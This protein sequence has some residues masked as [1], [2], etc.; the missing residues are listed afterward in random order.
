M[1]IIIPKIRMETEVRKL[2]KF[3]HVTQVVSTGKLPDFKGFALSNHRVVFFCKS[4]SSLN[5]I[6]N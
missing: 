4:N 6:S 2:T 5:S 1:M 3:F